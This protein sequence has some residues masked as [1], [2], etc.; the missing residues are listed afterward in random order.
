MERL[1]A[2]VGFER[3]TRCREK[4]GARDNPGKWYHPRAKVHA[5]RASKVMMIDDLPSGYFVPEFSQVI[6]PLGRP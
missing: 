4:A 1:C 6:C 2:S 5:Y 3:G